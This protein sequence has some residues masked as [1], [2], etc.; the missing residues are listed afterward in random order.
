MSS[1]WK[2]FDKDTKT[3]QVVYKKCPKI[4]KCHGSTTS[5][6]LYHLRTAHNIVLES[7]KES[8]ACSNNETGLLEKYMKKS[9]SN[10]VEEIICRCL[11]EDGMSTNTFRNSK[12]IKHYFIIRGLTM[13]TS[14]STIWKYV[15]KFYIAK[16]DE[17]VSELK[18]IRDR[19]GRF[20]IV[21]DEWTDVS[22]YKYVNICVKTYTEE[23][24]FKIFNLGL[25][26]LK[27][28]GTAENI[29]GSIEHKLKEFGINFENDVVC[30]T[31][32]G[33][34]VMG[35]YGDNITAES[36]LCINH[37]LHLAVVDTIYV[38]K[39]RAIIEESEEDFS[40]SEDET[41]EELQINNELQLKLEVQEA[42]CKLRK[43]VK[44]FNKSSH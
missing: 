37:A 44:L 43:T 25:E 7:K 20:S 3:S 38:R 26:E 13:P 28:K 35:K 32:D 19:K 39:D 12:L 4:Y 10:S 2:Y 31:H 24:S 5:T 1:A 14:N 9:S 6:L 21:V 29:Y 41:G 16:R 27:A 17:L 23:T 18:K 22:N 40:D 11:A 42:I 34:A 36:Q 33:A 8:T 15:E 30:S